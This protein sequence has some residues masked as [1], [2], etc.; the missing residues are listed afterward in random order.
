VGG[1]EVDL[2]EG[3]SRRKAGMRFQHRQLDVFVREVSLALKRECARDCKT[4]VYQLAGALKAHFAVEEG[5]IFPA[6]RGLRPDLS[7]WIATSEREHERLRHQLDRLT[8]ATTASDSATAGLLLEEFQAA[9]GAHEL[10]EDCIL[11]S[12]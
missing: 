2:R 5:V 9:L 1:E 12:A 10:D 7:N 3:L 8:C 6:L 4:A 11:E